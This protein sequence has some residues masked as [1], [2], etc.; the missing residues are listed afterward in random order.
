M[1]T[2]KKFASASTVIAFLLSDRVFCWSLPTTMTK[3][4]R[5]IQSVTSQSS[6]PQC[7]LGQAFYS[8][9]RRGSCS[10]F[11]HG[12]AVSPLSKG[13]TFKFDFRRNCVYVPRLIFT[14]SRKLK[15]KI[16]QLVKVPALRLGNKQSVEGSRKEVLFLI[17][18]IL[19]FPS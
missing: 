12:L 6:H 18:N 10:S 2:K 13:E 15:N 14:I 1:C 19:H 17:H 9:R 7:G 3:L 5:S 16:D 8:S 11:I 4:Y